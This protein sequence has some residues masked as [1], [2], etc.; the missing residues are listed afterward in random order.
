[1]SRLGPPSRLGEYTHIPALFGSLITSNLLQS[2]G[3]L[4]NL[5]WVL[6]G[7]VSS[8]KL[9]SAQGASVAKRILAFSPPH[10]YVGGIK[11]AG[12]VGTAVWWA[13]NFDG[14]GAL[15]HPLFAGRLPSLYTPSASCSC[16]PVW[17]GE[18]SGLHSSWDGS[19]LQ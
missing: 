4:I 10:H 16:G 17:Q 11:Q 7:G 19:S 9:C 6:A 3:T 5:R 2:I 18:P 1:M 14:D 12:N 8:G 13:M 15:A